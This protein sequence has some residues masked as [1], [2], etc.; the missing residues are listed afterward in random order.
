[1]KTEY[2]RPVSFWRLNIKVMDGTYHISILLF[3]NLL[4]WKPVCRAQHLCKIE[5][6]SF[7]LLAAIKQTQELLCVHLFTSAGS[8]LWLINYGL[9]GITA[10]LVRSLSSDLKLK[11]DTSKSEES[12]FV[13]VGWFDCNFGCWYSPLSCIL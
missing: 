10:D 5:K 11:F 12:E 6:G 7:G 4:N 1:M 3:F 13:Y 9:S 2:C 8:D